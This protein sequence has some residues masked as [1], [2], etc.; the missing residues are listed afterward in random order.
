MEDVSPGAAADMEAT[1]A[2]SPQR[3]EEAEVEE[4][5][6]KGGGRF[7]KKK[8]KKKKA[9]KEKVKHSKEK[10]RSGTAPDV[11]VAQNGGEAAH[12]WDTSGWGHGDEGARDARQAEP[13]DLHRR[14]SGI[15]DTSRPPA[16]V[17]GPAVADQADDD[18]SVN[19]RERSARRHDRPTSDVPSKSRSRSGSRKRLSSLFRRRG[20]SAA[21]DY[22]RS[23][24]ETDIRDGGDNGAGARE[25]GGESEESGL[26]ARNANSLDRGKLRHRASVDRRSSSSY[27]RQSASLERDAYRRFDPA[28]QPRDRLQN[29]T[30]KDALLEYRHRRLSSAER[31]RGER[32]R[33]VSASNSDL[34]LGESAASGSPTDPERDTGTT[35][36]ATLPRRSRPVRETSLLGDSPQGSEQRLRQS[37]IPDSEAM[38]DSFTR[39]NLGEQIQELCRTVND[40]GE[41]ERGGSR[42]GHNDTNDSA[43]SHGGHS[44]SPGNPGPPALLTDRGDILQGTAGG[45]SV[46]PSDTHFAPSPLE[47]QPADDQRVKPLGHFLQLR[48]STPLYSNS[49]LARE[50]RIGQSGESPPA[51]SSPRGP[52]ANDGVGKTDGAAVSP[53]SPNAQASSPSAGHIPHSGSLHKDATPVTSPEITVNPAQGALDSSVKMDSSMTME[54]SMVSSVDSGK[55]SSD[56]GFFSEPRDSD[57]ESEVDMSGFST[58][59]EEPGTPRDSSRHSLSPTVFVSNVNNLLEVPN[60]SKRSASVRVRRTEAPDA[61][62]EASSAFSRSESSKSDSALMRKKGKRSS[63]SQD[64][65]G[66]ERYGKQD[67]AVDGKAVEQKTVPVMGTSVQQKYRRTFSPVRGGAKGRDD[68]ALS[69]GTPVK[70]HMFSTSDQPVLYRAARGNSAGVSEAGPYQDPHKGQDAVDGREGEEREGGGKLQRGRSSQRQK[71]YVSSRSFRRKKEKDSKGDSSYKP[72]SSEAVPNQHLCSA[73]V[74]VEELNQRLAFQ[75]KSIQTSDTLLNELI[76]NTKKRKHGF[77]SSNSK[78]SKAEPSRRVSEIPVGLPPPRY[79]EERL[80][81]R[82]DTAGGSGYEDR[83]PS[84]S[85]AADADEVD[86]FHQRNEDD[87]EIAPLVDEAEEP[88]TEAQPD[89]APSP[90]KKS[91]GT[92][93]RAIVAL[94]QRLSRNRQKKE[95]KKK[96]NKGGEEKDQEAGED[97]PSDTFITIENEL[98]LSKLAEIKETDILDDEIIEPDFG[99]ALPKKQ[100]RFDAVSSDEP[101]QSEEPLPPLTPASRRLTARRN[102]TRGRERRRKCIHCC[103]K[104]VAFLFSHIGLCSLVVGYTILGGIVFQALEGPHEQQVKVEVKKNREKLLDDIKSLATSFQLNE[105]SVHNLTLELND[106]LLKYQKFIHEETTNHGWDGSENDPDVD[107][108]PKQWSFASALLYAITVMTTIGE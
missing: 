86:G 90:P 70:E 38:E 99:P 18:S 13:A 96:K 102:S 19:H 100:L 5:G 36:A 33:N 29:M 21:P 78:K 12:N 60:A 88:V 69:P 105:M 6:K 3:G 87:P 63:S 43:V 71:G 45:V 39:R 59:P 82:P 85:P 52:P 97:L 17:E 23:R 28:K 53:S 37:G 89:E 74:D 58:P 30:V 32:Q 79:E 76:K 8:D 93:L 2:A 66:G 68:A 57:S 49:P 50:R 14:D 98:N 22:D 46:S 48:K 26:K 25:T 94:K 81:D 56:Q 9:K 4:K 15:A 27:S 101:I 62:P 54:S 83:R 104:F 40:G 84:P 35:G 95:G 107:D 16:N 24:S 20:R 55:R 64:G 31:R 103:K 41:A 77:F 72:A 80:V 108:Q 44:E 61:A 11:D 1:A 73:D 92:S 7:S 51:A 47:G 75:D 42:E 91:R 106:H 10:S 65:Q 67:D 34:P